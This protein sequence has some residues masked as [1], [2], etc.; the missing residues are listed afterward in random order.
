[1]HGGLGG[2]GGSNVSLLSMGSVMTSP[3]RPSPRAAAA[4]S[5]RSAA[6]ATT[7]GGGQASLGKEDG[8][9]SPRRAVSFGGEN[10]RPM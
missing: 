6:G 9:R 7:S 2:G 3:S 10:H 1:M 8:V 5:P 4:S